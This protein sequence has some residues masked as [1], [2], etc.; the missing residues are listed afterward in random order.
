MT[1]IQITTRCNMCCPHCAYSCTEEGVDITLENFKKAV[2]VAEEIEVGG[3]CIGGGEPTLHP[4][5]WEIMGVALGSW[6]LDDLHL[7]IATNGSN[8]DISMRLAHMARNGLIHAALSVDDFHLGIDESVLK[9]FG[10]YRFKEKPSWPYVGQFNTS[11]TDLREIRDVSSNV[12]NQGRAVENGLGI[13]DRCV[14]DDLFIT[15]DGTI[16]M[17]GC[18]DYILGDIFNGY[19]LP[20]GYHDLDERCSKEYFKMLEEEEVI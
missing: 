20:E 15:P 6:C 18:Q 10:Y 8:K 9:A 4:Q 7:F 3:L 5:F 12:A 1:Y 14:C 19:E 17:C 16:Y 11:P 2:E 13:S